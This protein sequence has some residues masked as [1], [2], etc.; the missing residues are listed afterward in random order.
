M[1]TAQVIGI[2][3]PEKV[4]ISVALAFAR[5]FIR[6]A[7]R[8]LRGGRSNVTHARNQLKAALAEIGKTEDTVFCRCGHSDFA[9][10]GGGGDGGCTV[11]GCGCEVFTTE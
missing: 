3:S 4:G 6:E 5:L 8:E 7:E 10:L 2:D 9:H 11:V 1:N